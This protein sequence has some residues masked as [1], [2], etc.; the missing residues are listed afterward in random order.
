MKIFKLYTYDLNAEDQTCGE[1]G[2]YVT[3]TTCD[4]CH[5]SDIQTSYSVNN[6][7]HSST[8]EAEDFEQALQLLD[9]KMDVIEIDNNCDN[10]E[11]VYFNYKTGK[12]AGS[13]ACEIR[14]EANHE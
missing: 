10:T 2:N 5:S 4:N 1:C 14:E 6:V 13:P 7:Y 9:L 12:Y 3:E 8:I 11:T